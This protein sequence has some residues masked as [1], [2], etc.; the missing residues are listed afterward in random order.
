M[1]QFKAGDVMYHPRHGRV[2]LRGGA[3]E[4]KGVSVELFG[5]IHIA[6]LSYKPW[7]AP[8][9][10]RPLLDGWYVATDLDEDYLT[11][12][13]VL[14]GSW[15]VDGRETNGEAYELVH[16]LGTEIPKTL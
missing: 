4:N 6:L 14:W 5:W 1:N 3:V 8:V 9:H 11:L 10:E 7:P 16:Y 15:F 13:Q 2:V 12:V